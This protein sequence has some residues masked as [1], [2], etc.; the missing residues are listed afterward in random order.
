MIENPIIR[1]FHPDPSIIRVGN[2]YYIATSTFEWWPGVEI[3]HSSDLK[4]WNFHSRALKRESQLCLRGVPDGGGVYAPCL[5]YCDG[6]F[7]LVFTNVRQRGSFMQTDNYL[8][9]T[10]DINK[11]WSEPIYLNSLGF[12]PS[13]FHDDDGR[14]YLLSLDNHYE[15]GKRFNGLWLQ[16]YDGKARRLVGEIKQIYS[17]P[18]LVEGAHLYKHG[19]MYYLLKA[20]G[21][22]GE[23][24]SCQLSRSKNLWGKYEDCPRILLHSR[25]NPD[26]PLQQGGHGDLVTTPEGDI[27]LVHLAR[28]K[29]APCCGRESCIQKL[30]ETH[31]GWLRLA[32]GGE[33]PHVFVTEAGEERGKP[34][35]E[36]ERSD[37]TRLKKMPPCFMS[38]RGEVKD[39]RLCEKGLVL[40]GKDAPSSKF[41]QSL[42]ARR[43]TERDFSAQTKLGFAPESEK[44]L[45]GLML[46][47]DTSN[48]M[49]LYVTKGALSSVARVL[50]CDGGALVYNDE[51]IPVG[52]TTVL[53]CE[54]KN[55]TVKFFADAK[56]FKIEP[57]LTVLSDDHVFLGFTGA[58]V[59]IACYDLYMRE[60]EA[61]FEYFEYKA[62]V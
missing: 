33:N 49:L 34:H 46:M 60:K 36:E 42:F 10:T 26:L 4:N 51:E 53:R 2:D 47:Y 5:S 39:A 22:T 48:W 20:Q 58:C 12:D 3:W 11:D 29:D 55:N 41:N 37:F 15:K 45:A 18:E 61:T 35:V 27:Y 54:A 1:G 9:T 23:R 59:G 44:H 6:V 43:I 30:E 52:E 57:D 28:R 25:D 14:K 7:Y 16:E 8:V 56:T 19:G 21:G 24:H 50:M 32:Q 62:R 38:L 40:K 31:D 17:I 13:L